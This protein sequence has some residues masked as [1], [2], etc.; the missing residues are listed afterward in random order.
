MQDGRLYVGHSNNPPRRHTEH[1]SGK[2]CRTTGIFGAG[3]IIFVEQYSDRLSAAHRERQTC[4]ERS[5]RVKGWTRAKKLALAA[6]NLSDLHVLAKRR[7]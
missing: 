5:R 7:S 4:P 2:G 6:G 3:D 1:E